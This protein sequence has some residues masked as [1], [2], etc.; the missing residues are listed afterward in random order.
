MKIDGLEY[1]LK[2][3]YQ[4]LFAGITVGI[5][6]LPLALAFAI[7]SGVPPEK[8]I[9]TAVVA[10][11]LISFLGGS[12]LQIGGPT[13]AFVV[14]IYDI[15]YKFGYQGLIVAGFLAGVILVLL[16]LFKIGSY[17]KFIP[18]PVTTGFTSGIAVIIASTQVKDFLGLKIEKVP[19]NFIEKWLVYFENIQSLNLTTVIMGLICILVLI[20]QRKFFPK[21]PGAIIV[22]LLA[23]FANEFFHLSLETIG[24]K[25]GNLPSSVPS[26]SFDFFRPSEFIKYLPHAFTIAML[27]AIESLLSA[28]V[29]DSMS[30]DKHNSNKELVA[31]GVANIASIIFGGIPAT[32]AIAR[33]ATNIKSGAQTSVSGM[34][35]AIT[36]FLLLFFLSP[37]ASKIPL[38]SLS[39]VLMLVSWNMAELEHFKDLLRSPKSDVLVL[40]ATFFLTIF[41]DLVLAVEV[42]MI[43][44]AFLFM[45][46]MSEAV[47]IIVDTPVLSKD[48]ISAQKE[49]TH[50]AEEDVPQGV[51][52][53]EI[54][55]PLF[56]GVADR[57]RS[58]F[59]I[60]ED[61]PKAIILRMHDVTVID[62]TGIYALIDLSNRCKK[63][64]I[65]LILSAMSS[66]LELKLDKA[67]FFEEFDSE[68]ICNNIYEALGK[69]RKL[70]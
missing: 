59:S 47:N 21:I 50:L 20:F 24:L 41:V 68:N 30:G 51:E 2:I 26:A 60:I 12:R 35:H 62:A 65:I 10:G 38:V 45:K 56:F 37:L 16:G 44:A 33:T 63:D 58:V 43:L 39:A 61:K 55:G 9:Y 40:L 6:A 22:I 23:S 7:A 54:H 8:G 13:G 17:I 29:A 49:P 28:V 69:A 46:R 52:V 67:G 57:L 14:I 70:S 36:L 4:D 42:G 5:V 11:F 27:A 64:G 18:F 1:N 53:L 34:I 15:I 3:F 19:A 66:R 32:G 25:F 31:Q 48:E